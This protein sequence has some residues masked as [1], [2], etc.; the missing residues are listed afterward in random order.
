MF[1]VMYIDF[2]AFQKNRLDR[3]NKARIASRTAYADS[4]KKAEQMIDAWNNGIDLEPP[5]NVNIFDVQ[6]NHL[7][8]CLEN[9]VVSITFIDAV[10]FLFQL[11]FHK[12]IFFVNF[13]VRIILLT[14]LSWN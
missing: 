14:F 6:I 7:L 12:I 3:I 10:H 11:S 13:H 1:A 5:A 8:M 2:V 4:R 9:T